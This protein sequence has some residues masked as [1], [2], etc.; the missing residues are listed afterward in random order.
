M[1]TLAVEERT[2]ADL[3]TQHLEQVKEQEDLAMVQAQ[4]KELDKV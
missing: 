1:E 4:D 2:Q 3:Q